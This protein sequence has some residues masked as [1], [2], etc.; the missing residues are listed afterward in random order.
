MRA[1]VIGEP[2]P[3][4]THTKSKLCLRVYIRA[5]R[6]T[7]KTRCI[8]LISVHIQTVVACILKSVIKIKQKEERQSSFSNACQNVCCVHRCITKPWKEKL[9]TAI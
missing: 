4:R 5:S 1:C 3:I 2:E 9:D 7:K 6:K 8:C